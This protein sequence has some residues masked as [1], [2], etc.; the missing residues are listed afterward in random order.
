MR[1]DV[2]R[3]SCLTVY[4]WRRSGTGT[5]P[6]SSAMLH[7]GWTCA[8]RKSYAA[9]RPKRDRRTVG[10]FTPCSRSRRLLIHYVYTIAGLR[11]STCV[12]RNEK[13]SRRYVFFLCSSH[14][15]T[16]LHQT[17]PRH[18]RATRASPSYASHAIHLTKSTLFLNLVVVANYSALWT[19]ETGYGGSLRNGRKL[20]GHPVR[21]I[22][23][24]VP[25]TQGARVAIK[26]YV[27]RTSNGRRYLHQ[28][29]PWLVYS[30]RQVGGGFAEH[31]WPPATPEN[32]RRNFC[33]Q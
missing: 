30:D 15:V 10:A 19:R 32:P 8:S 29:S 13:A 21:G 18:T 20:S 9:G 12:E 3:R 6:F 16:V 28:R 25:R 17:L 11:L 1:C 27:A 31:P 2:S 14:T 5:K 26:R 23:Y 22:E 33:A 4:C 7:I 24:S